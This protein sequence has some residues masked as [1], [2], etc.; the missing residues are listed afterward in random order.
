[1]QKEVRQLFL[2]CFI[3]DR[4][5]AS[6]LCCS[7]ELVISTL[8]IQLPLKNFAN[9]GAITQLYLAIYTAK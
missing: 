3:T 4:E 5:L 8:L 7:N 2:A 9:L 1:M 6:F